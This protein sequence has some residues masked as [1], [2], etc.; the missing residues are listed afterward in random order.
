MGI[1]DQCCGVI[2]GE[3]RAETADLFERR[4]ANRIVRTDTQRRKIARVAC[5]EGSMEGTFDI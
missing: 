2:L 4:C 1:H 5:L 3:F